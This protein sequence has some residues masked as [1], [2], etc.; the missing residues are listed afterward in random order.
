MTDVPSKGVGNFGRIFIPP[1][2]RTKPDIGQVY[3]DLI[4]E[5]TKSRIKLPNPKLDKIT[6][7]ASR[8]FAT[9]IES[10]L[11]SNSLRRVSSAGLNLLH[12]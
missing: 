2:E 10:D 6:Q 5:E 7:Q 1:N 11:V 9:G 8:L 12:E 3:Y 4:L